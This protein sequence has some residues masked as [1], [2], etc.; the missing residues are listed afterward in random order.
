[1]A[2]DNEASCVSD[3]NFAVICSFLECFGKSCGIEYPDIALL[4]EMVENAQEVPQ[5][6]IDLHI[7]LLRK[8]RK[9][10]SAEKWERALVKF[11]HT[12]SNQ[13]GW[14]LERF[15]YKKARIAVKLR[16]LKVLLEAQFDLNQRFKNEV[17]KLAASELRVE[18]LGRD[19]SGLAYWCQLDEECNIRVYR[20]DLDEESWQLV[21][22]D[23]D[24]VV[25]LI[26]TLTNG[27]AGDILETEDSNSL[28]ISEKPIIDTGQV[29]TSPSLEEENRDN[30]EVAVVEGN[31]KEDVDSVEEDLD[32]EEDEE[33]DEEDKE[34]IQGEEKEEN[35]KMDEEEEDD[36]E[37]DEEDVT[38]E[39]SSQQNTEDDSQDVGVLCIE[40]EVK[41]T[42]NLEN[43]SN[44]PQNQ[45]KVPP[46]TLN[47]SETVQS[48]KISYSEA[49]D[50]PSPAEPRGKVYASQETSDQEAKSVELKHIETPVIKTSPIK[51]VNI[52]NL[53]K[54]A[55]EKKLDL[56]VPTGITL[57]PVTKPIARDDVNEPIKSREN[58]PAKSS[59]VFYSSG[60]PILAQNK[61][62]VTPINKL[63][64]NLS[65][66]Q[67]EKLEKLSGS[68]SLEKIAENLARSS[69]IHG[70]VTSPEED[71][72]IPEFFSRNQVDKSRAS[73][74]QGG[75]DLSTS[76]RGWESISDR[77]RPVD[78]SGIDLSS[79][80]SVSSK[81]AEL[82]SP[83][84]R[85]Q[86][87][88][89]REIDLSTRKPG[90]P[91]LSSIRFD[92]RTTSRNHP[93]VT[94]F[95]KRQ[96][97]PPQLPFA[98][99]DLPPAYR[100][101][102]RLGGTDDHRLPNYSM[103]PE[104]SKLN[105][106]RMGGKRPLEEDD[107]P[108]DI[109]KRIHADVI[110]IR[111]TIDKRQM[112]G[113]NWRDEV[114]EAIEEPV[115]RVQGQ[116]SGSECD[117]VNP[118]I[119]EAIDEPVMYF[120]GEGLGSESETGNPGD[121]TSTDN[122]VSKES[123]SEQTSSSLSSLNLPESQVLPEISPSNEGSIESATADATNSQ[124]SEI[125]AQTN[126]STI[127]SPEASAGKSKFKPTLGVQVFAKSAAVSPVKRLSRWDVGRPA[128]KT[129]TGHDQP[130]LPAEQQTSISDTFTGPPQG[131][132]ESTSFDQNRIKESTP[133]TRIKLETVMS[134][135]DHD[136]DAIKDVE[137]STLSENEIESCDIT[138]THVLESEKSEKASSQE[139]VVDLEE[140]SRHESTISIG[141]G[142]IKA[143]LPGLL[144]VPV[145]EIL[146]EK[147]N[148]RDTNG[149]T[150]Q[151]FEEKS[152]NNAD[153][154]DETDTLA[155]SDAPPPR[156]FFG[157]N[158]VSY[159]LK[160]DDKKSDSVSDTACKTSVSQCEQLELMSH[161]TPSVSEVT[162][163][164]E[165]ES[166]DKLA[167]NLAQTVGIESVDTK[168]WHESLD[169]SIDPQAV[170]AG[171]NK[172]L[173]DKI[174]AESEIVDSKEKLQE[175][176]VLDEESLD[177]ESFSGDATTYASKS[178]ESVPVN[179]QFEKSVFEDETS[180][181]SVVSGNTSFG[182]SNVAKS[183]IFP[184]EEVTDS[185]PVSENFAKLVASDT[186]T[187]CV[188]VVKSLE[189]LNVLKN[190]TEH[191]EDSIDHLA[192][193]ENVEKTDVLTQKSDN[194]EELIDSPVEGKISDRNVDDSPRD[195]Q[196]VEQSTNFVDN[197][198]NLN[199]LI[200]STPGTDGPGVSIDLIKEKSETLQKSSHPPDGSGSILGP[201]SRTANEKVEDAID[202]LPDNQS[203][204]TV[205][206]S[207]M[208]L[209]VVEESTKQ[210]ED[211][212]SDQQ[213]SEDAQRLENEPHEQLH[214]EIPE[215][216][217]SDQQKSKD[218]RRPEIVPHEQLGAE[219]SDLQGS[220]NVQH[221]GNEPCDQ[222]A[223]DV[224]DHQES[225]DLPERATEPHQLEKR[226]A[227]PQSGLE[228]VESP[229]I[230]SIGSEDH[231][232]G[233]SVQDEEPKS[234]ESQ[235]E[236]PSAEQID[237][238][239][240]F[241]ELPESQGSNE[242]VSS[243]NED[244]LLKSSSDSEQDQNVLREKT[245]V[246]E[247]LPSKSQSIAVESIADE[248]AG[249]D[250][251]D[252]LDKDGDSGSSSKPIENQREFTSLEPKEISTE[253]LA[254]SSVEP[255]LSSCTGN[256]HMETYSSHQKD[257]K[258]VPQT[259]DAIGRER[260]TLSESG[261]DDDR[262]QDVEYDAI[263]DESKEKSISAANE[264]SHSEPQQIFRT[265]DL[266]PVEKAAASPLVELPNAMDETQR[267]ED[268]KT[269]EAVEKYSAIGLAESGASIKDDSYFKEI[270]PAAIIDLN[271]SKSPERMTVESKNDSRAGISIQTGIVDDYCNAVSENPSP[272]TDQDSNEAMVIDDRVYDSN[273]SSKD[274]SNEDSTLDKGKAMDDK[275]R[276]FEHIATSNE[277]R[278]TADSNIVE[279]HEILSKNNIDE[280]LVQVNEISRFN[281]AVVSGDSKQES[282]ASPLIEF[283]N[284]STSKAES[285]VVPN[286]LEDRN[287]EAGKL[288]STELGKE[289]ESE[290]I[291]E[292]LGGDLKCE[293]NPLGKYT[294]ESE[295]GDLDDNVEN[296]IQDASTDDQKSLVANYD[297]SD[298][299][300]DDVFENDLMESK[301]N[302]D[303]SESM[304]SQ[305]LLLDREKQQDSLPQVDSFGK[306]GATSELSPKPNEEISDH[307]KRDTSRLQT[308]IAEEKIN[309]GTDKDCLKDA[310]QCND[311][312]N[313]SA[314]NLDE[315]EEAKTSSIKI[316]LT[317]QGAEEVA[318]DDKK[319]SMDSMAES[320]T[321][322]LIE[323][324]NDTENMTESITEHTEEAKESLV[325]LEKAFDAKLLEETE[326]KFVSK[327][328]DEDSMKEAEIKSLEITDNTSQEKSTNESVPF[329]TQD[330]ILGSEKCGEESISESVRDFVD[331][332]AKDERETNTIEHNEI[333]SASTVS[334]LHAMQEGP[335]SESLEKEILEKEKPIVT[336]SLDVSSSVLSSS[337]AAKHL[338]EPDT[339]E[340]NDSD[341]EED[342]QFEEESAIVHHPKRFKEDSS[343]SM[344]AN[345]ERES[346]VTS[347]LA[348][349]LK[350]RDETAGSDLL[351][352]NISYVESKK[353]EGSEY[354][355][356]LESSLLDNNRI[357]AL[358][359]NEIT[360]SHNAA[361]DTPA[362]I[363]EKMDTNRYSSDFVAEIV[364]AKIFHLDKVES[365]KETID[366]LED[367]SKAKQFNAELVTKLNSSVNEISDDSVK[368][369]ASQK[370][371]LSESMT[372]F[373]DE[374]SKPEADTTTDDLLTN[375]MHDTGKE[376]E[377][378]SEIQSVNLKVITI[379]S[380]DS[381]GADNEDPFSNSQIEMDPLACI[382]EDTRSKSDDT[383]AASLGIRVKPV[384]ELVYEGWKLDGAETPKISRK[385]RNSHH[386]S[387]SEDT[388]MK[389][390]D[391]ESEGT[392]GK[393]MRL[394]GKRLPN[395]NLRR[396]VEEKRQEAASSDDENH[397]KPSSIE[398]DDSKTG[399]DVTVVENSSS[400]DKKTRGRPRGKRKVRR[401]I[402]RPG[403]TAPA[404][405]T[406]Q[407]AVP[408]LSATTDLQTPVLSSPAVSGDT[409]QKKRKKRK[410]VLGLEIGRDI[411]DT[412]QSGALLNENPV[413][414]SRRI[415][416]LKI[417]EEADRRRIE[418]E[419]L[420]ELKE[421]KDRDSVDKKKRKKQKPESEE[422]VSFKE[423]VERE[424]KPK[425]K[426][427]TK[428]KKKKAES[429]FD[430]TNPWRSS[431]GS[432][433]ED[434][435]DHDEDDDE[436]EEAE[437]EGSVLFKSDHEFSPESDLEKDEESEPLRRARTA[438]KAQS[439]D[440]EADDEYACQKCGKADHPEWILL[441][442]T[443]DKGWHCSCLRPALMLIPEGDWFCPP[444]QH[445]L[446][447]LKLQENL[448]KYDKYTKRHEN[449]L[450]RKKRLA[451]VGISLDN[452]LHR[453]ETQ[454]SSRASS[455]ESDNES[456]SSAS[457][458]SSGS[459]SSDDSQPVYQLR[460][461]RCANTYKFNEYDD[462][463][464][465]AIQDEVEAVRGAGNQGRGKDIA[466]IVNAEKEEA[467]A[468]AFKKNQLEGD[469]DENDDRKL[470][471]E[472]DEDYKAER[473]EDL[474]DDDDEDDKPKVS[475][476]KILSRKK[477]R[478]LNSLD[479]SSEDDPE[480][481]ED[482]K[483]SISDEEDDLD[484]QGSSSDEST[485][486][487]TRRQRGRRGGAPVRRSTRARMTRYDEDF[488]NDDSEDSDK[489]KRKKS[490]SVWEESESEESDN[491]WRQR[492]KRR[493]K[494]APIPKSRSSNK[495]KPKKKSKK[496]RIIES[497]NQSEDDEE[498]E[499]STHINESDG[500]EEI[501]SVL[502]QEQESE[503]DEKRILCDQDG[504]KIE[505]KIEGNQENEQKD[506]IP[507]VP[508]D[509][510]KLAKKK[511][512]NTPKRKKTPPIRR[513]I[514]YGGL[515]DGYPK[516]E[517]ETLGR[518]TRGKKINYQE[519]M[520]SDS[521][522]ELKKALKKT[523][524]SEDEFVVNEV[525]EL[526]EE[527]E[528]DSDSGDIYSPK[529]EGP[530]IKGKS[531]K[532]KKP[533]KSKS[534]AATKMKLTNEHDATPKAK[535]KP[536][537]KPG[538]KNKPKSQKMMSLPF[539]NPR[540]GGEEGDVTEEG[541]LAGL[542]TDEFAELDEEQLDQ[543]MM[544]EDEEYGKRQLELAAIEIAKKKKE[545]RE[546][547]KLEKARLKALEILAAERQRDPN[548]PE[549]TDGE[550]PKKK[551][552]GRR[553]KAEILA[554]QM[555][556]DG[557]PNLSI[558][559]TSPNVTAILS[560]TVTLTPT[561]SVT[562]ISSPSVTT[563]NLTPNM[564]SFLSPNPGMNLAPN[565][566]PTL[567]ANMS[568]IATPEAQKIPENLCPVVIGPDT[569]AFSPESM[570]VKPK[571]RG[572][573]KGKKTLALEAARAAEA[574]AKGIDHISGFGTDSNP[575]MKSDDPN[576]LPTPGSSTSGSAP[577]TPPASIAVVQQGTP[578]SQNQPPPPNVSIQ[579][580]Q[581]YPSMS[582]VQQQQ[583]QQPQSSV[584]TRMLQ[585]Q[586]VSASPQSFAA[587][588]AAMGHKYF[589]TS[590]TAGNIMGVPRA[591]FDIQPRGR[592]T[593]PYRQPGQ[594]PMPPHFAAVRSGTPP[595][596]M[597]V[598]GPQMYHTPH[599]PMD[600]SPSGGG[601]ISISSSRDRSSPLGSGAGSAMIPPAAGSPLTK[602]GPT[603]PPPPPYARGVPPMGRFP[604]GSPMGGPR[605]QMP[606][607][608]NAAATNHGMQ[609][610]SPP[611]S[612]T[613]GNFSPYH[614]PPP[615]N[616]H[617]GAYPPPPPM[618]TADD[619]AAYQGSPYPT[620]HFS[621]PAENP[622]P[623][624]PPPPPQAQA[625][626]HT[627]AHPPH[628][629]HP[630]THSHPHP[631]AGET[632]GP[633]GNKQFDEEG[634]GEFGGLVS[635][636]SSQRED[637]LD[638]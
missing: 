362:F 25:S 539:N 83:G 255:A 110:P 247:E 50:I 275:K 155:S 298:R 484:D 425:K 11:C 206:D 26:S 2:S 249:I 192:E 237:E 234:K 616:Y 214:V 344:L 383:N 612:R 67:S 518:R 256:V 541:S 166:I 1:M 35:G 369:I 537:P 473:D 265:A 576:I 610:P 27:E 182:K 552:R 462:M 373:A 219:I 154:P 284:E 466:T 169:Q 210:S 587:A 623:I 530:K 453:N 534:P 392:G 245:N 574:A 274:V 156:F 97:L 189:E 85:P 239:Q 213:K 258:L 555:R 76:P 324:A 396:T 16:L 80:K 277:P 197:A 372:T 47:L 137:D 161:V 51:V 519:V 492:K 619:A 96:T 572:R 82:P 59:N 508:M 613:T 75:I 62:S 397:K 365:E 630:H 86:D 177:K 571:R 73:R 94:D 129:D 282:A 566:T 446:L 422:E 590:N 152:S 292:N 276:S 267:S 440:E 468:E 315:T 141:A 299:E 338:L 331:V 351:N 495:S 605:H 233:K 33:E 402:C 401:I 312:T 391:D 84:Y 109:I 273:E 42:A 187:D 240:S 411:I 558:E 79:R 536:G 371:S 244:E 511:K 330:E 485:F 34:N 469:E 88:Q 562:P 157:P 246:E 119:G 193:S 66:L 145:A 415:A 78:F 248:S 253:S 252:I 63:A 507:M 302:I 368:L 568:P 56:K 334:D 429:K 285:E 295:Y 449:E 404:S 575:E 607:F 581:S 561:T 538:S 522:E 117:T 61:I 257:E 354:P 506:G 367:F 139:S 353:L 39:E 191:I 621:T 37:G 227:I 106:V 270:T 45:A 514:I 524:E 231:L 217:D 321:D 229:V 326:S 307:A 241:E 286:Q 398:K 343:M 384:S 212:V 126:K 569:H 40:S 175:D 591:G 159:N 223:G 135:S 54:P 608:A 531:P 583:S 582:P 478:K 333:L 564:S 8:T 9:T 24:G 435:D 263:N 363:A 17:N 513:K 414:Q 132:M 407:S 116:G 199:E 408:E 395:M 585:S 53:T 482:F 597:R 23:R 364:E 264:I 165:K 341:E 447:V 463:I 416:Q 112:I 131:S 390:D 601:P 261:T 71:R 628:P 527:A 614:P 418:E 598:P 164:T 65:K 406:N 190:E 516:Q 586:P 185:V 278:S 546:A 300:S 399:D 634:S 509:A 133:E 291:K 432:S 3:P 381:M 281:M 325:S 52:A 7:K 179:E 457:S 370:K 426:H 149:S 118:G 543:M 317:E 413:R 557:A 195:A 136:S 490:R 20:E 87:F 455:Q 589:G 320:K 153:L 617:Y 625:P 471:K 486:A 489:P 622:A 57:T 376:A 113:S 470:E 359:S 563:P 89:H 535:R 460:E 479:I 29:T 529:K 30:V 357:T 517:E 382:D 550:A 260:D 58:V 358:K 437:S 134:V 140:S 579:S 5:Q 98:N 544:M 6:L 69:G 308:E 567:V 250:H 350:N 127:D 108:Q 328:V 259:T 521:E 77:N 304:E 115:M 445:N 461:R 104:L 121:E 456:S 215:R 128:E 494:T 520:A 283:R 163:H 500:A 19:K 184:T 323:Q 207:Q 103:V 68:K 203:I 477:H 269:V 232:E 526:N 314:S 224:S 551:K 503:N 386:E 510:E 201:D 124:E 504:V 360:L 143:I 442:D 228:P 595:M 337:T 342:E 474:D 423:I 290:S 596:R 361:K 428:I 90:R 493:S 230:S 403:R 560:P 196:S 125:D 624:Q 111:S 366:K 632:G 629:T 487:D 409:P 158:C 268:C 167:K 502:D 559:S 64:A 120:Y 205:A 465:A 81:G 434:E 553:S 251:E 287:N 332:N 130:D 4:Q 12:Y 540:S 532:G 438:Q 176:P 303:E 188:P 162:E 379:E 220:K 488:I 305:E 556:R 481:D 289:V 491:S 102:V 452:V 101:S 496:K 22:K 310:N 55:E 99:Y 72:Q 306:V 603:P 266:P 142:L 380:D 635:Y 410:M 421:K 377:G 150:K 254:A 405:D 427:K 636:F 44:Q 14:E 138:K 319:E 626:P 316:N 533:R 375:K 528:K 588:A 620:E 345:D 389:D 606:P 218:L 105:A 225:E 464:N 222:I 444:C 293:S 549:G 309:E 631:H 288:A 148:L 356:S 346:N 593:L 340:L 204:T 443:C 262:S 48:S 49:S 475:A 483:G 32:E 311:N 451:Y 393:R 339:G 480:S 604:E 501:Q 70:M 441:C 174:Y 41:R 352:H 570:L 584:I 60:E 565:L 21:A 505:Q 147:D 168:R 439:D 242:V 498:I 13:D 28:E 194:P 599:H 114:G 348:K 542:G 10:V 235:I 454:K 181:S 609:Q 592:I 38:N 236:N 327:T 31:G 525:E 374:T 95:S 93:I 297:S 209:T 279:D 545:E 436:E 280:D 335:V 301:S 15:G 221:L 633:G 387:N 467:Q 146:A 450:L 424:T 122:E 577:S 100:S 107:V 173:D 472:S 420:C 208:K 318:A 578:S 226:N 144:A 497:D 178:V 476:R 611:P 272:S 172:N 417:K 394:R 271:I 211:E 459:S 412:S 419:T 355:E 160:S 458:S 385:R 512:E 46:C 433:T 296:A 523:E 18:P 600:P 294:V 180:S 186:E 322:D 547:K 43:L 200:G 627:H 378:D 347:L 615:P 313:F 216:Q 430:E 548:A 243:S 618:T 336:N 580:S 123:K 183:E 171:E 202:P 388:A 602:G 74:S 594:S 499:P 349:D 637:D 91:D 638:S 36:E 400:N 515:S 238:K 554:E 431:S 170:S 573:G 92:A 329:L 198:E 448:K 151:T